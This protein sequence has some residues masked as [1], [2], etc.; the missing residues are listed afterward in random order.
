MRRHGVELSNGGNEHGKDVEV[1]CGSVSGM[2]IST[3]SKIGFGTGNGVT[4]IGTRLGDIWIESGVRFRN[5]LSKSG[6]GSSDGLQGFNWLGA[7]VD[8]GVV[9]NEDIKWEFNEGIYGREGVFEVAVG[10]NKVL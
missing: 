6:R 9:L 2:V 10:V 4:E 8:F 5:L 7:V 3:G 1:C